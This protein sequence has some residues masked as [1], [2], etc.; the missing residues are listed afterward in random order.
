MAQ[1]LYYN[2]SL[3]PRTSEVTDRIILTQYNQ[4]NYCLNG[5]ILDRV[6]L[7]IAPTN[8]GKSCFSSSLIIDAIKQGINTFL[9]AGE[10]G[11]AEARDRVYRQYLGADKNNYEYVAYVSNGK[12]TNA[13]E[14]LIKPEK[15]AEAKAFFDDKLFIYNNNFPATRE[16]L[17]NCLTEAHTRDNCRFFVI[18]NCEMFNLDG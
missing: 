2:S 6:S 18:D 5:L 10:D 1:N 8:A 4:L 16:N 13:G 9:F 17:I 3:I 15:F 14:N 7:L 11:G 12:N